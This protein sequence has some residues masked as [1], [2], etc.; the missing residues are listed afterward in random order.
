MPRAEARRGLPALEGKRIW[1]TK[2]SSWLIHWA[3]KKMGKQK[4]T[5][6]FAEVKRMM[7]P[8]EAL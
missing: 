3:K 6:K 5:R 4:K 2:R 7:N 8:K 1:G